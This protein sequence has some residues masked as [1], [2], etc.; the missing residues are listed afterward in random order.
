MKGKAKQK[1]EWT[2]PK[3]QVLQVNADTANGMTT[4]M[5]TIMMGMLSAGS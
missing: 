5:E 3:V 4:G 2:S 1:K